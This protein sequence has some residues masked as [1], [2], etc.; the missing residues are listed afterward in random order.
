MGN[1]CCESTIE[2]DDFKH[3]CM[4]AAA[5]NYKPYISKVQSTKVSLDQ[6]H[7]YN[8]EGDWQKNAPRTGKGR[9]FFRRKVLL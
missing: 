9:H 5:N 6:K 3:F 1:A 4:E 7:P 8:C 2:H